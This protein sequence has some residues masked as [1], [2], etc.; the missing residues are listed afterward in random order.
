MI[1]FTLARLNQSTK[2]ILNFATEMQSNLKKQSTKTMSMLFCCLYLYKAKL[3]ETFFVATVNILIQ[4]A[5]PTFP[6]IQKKKSTR[7]ALEFIFLVSQK[8]VLYKT[9]NPLKRFWF[10]VDSSVS[11]TRKFCFSFMTSVIF[12]FV[13]LIVNLNC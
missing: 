1:L 8:F 5:L 7:I 2:Y 12:L 3:F 13:L 6:E 11:S 10:T 4:C 9:F